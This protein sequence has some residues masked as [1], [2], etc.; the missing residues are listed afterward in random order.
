[1]PGLLQGVGPCYEILTDQ[2]A[3][4]SLARAATVGVCASEANVA[5]SLARF[6]AGNP[7]A[8]VSTLAS[9]DAAF[10]DCASTQGA[11]ALPAGGATTSFSVFLPTII[12]Q[13][14]SIDADVAR[15]RPTVTPLDPNDPRSTGSL[16]CGN[17][18][19]RPVDYPQLA[20]RFLVA[21][22]LAEDGTT[23]GSAVVVDGGTLQPLWNG[24]LS[25]PRW[26][27]SATLLEDGTVLIAGGVGD[28]GEI[29]PGAELFT[30]DE[31][32]RVGSMSQ[33]RFRHT[34]TVL[35][36][37][38]VLVTGG[39][40]TEFSPGGIRVAQTTASAEIYDP[41][42]RTFLPVREMSIPRQRHTATLLASSGMVLIAGGDGRG[43][44][45]PP[46]EPTETSN[47]LEL[48]DPASGSFVPSGL[49]VYPRNR[50]TATYLPR[51]TGTGEEY[52]LM[53][54]GT[55]GTSVHESSE[56]L[57]IGPSGSGDLPTLR[58]I[59]V[60]AMPGLRDHQAV[61]TAACYVNLLGGTSNV[62]GTHPTAMALFYF[63]PSTTGGPGTWYS[64]SDIPSPVAL[65]GAVNLIGNRWIVVGGI[66]GY[67][68]TGEPAWQHHNH[69][70]SLQ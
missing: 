24:S 32:V 27:A 12:T 65:H 62:S 2:P 51:W 14:I 45:N 13:W 52:V 54:G 5:A 23:L 67:S 26:G 58:R 61:A 43:F 50:H 3:G 42:T 68:D 53:A 49:M 60:Q 21:G 20:G 40:T 28:S 8:G 19:L 10:L 63:G 9:A 66:A 25:T 46:G 69:V 41:L 44:E 17:P 47:R 7:Q 15:A 64:R 48:F 33:A 38:R 16:L 18:R 37:G 4:F 30:G 39:R 56:L 22:G 6:D 36:D 31:F 35:A 34:A 59:Y 57:V 55:D 11:G 70:M 1:M 29:L